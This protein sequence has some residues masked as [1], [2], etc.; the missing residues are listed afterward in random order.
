MRPEWFDLPDSA[1]EPSQ[2]K[3]FPFEKMW[4]DAKLWIPLMLSGDHFVGRMD[5]GPCSSKTNADD[6]AMTRWWIGTRRDHVI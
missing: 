4:E 6:G 3:P 5:F 2:N 1:S